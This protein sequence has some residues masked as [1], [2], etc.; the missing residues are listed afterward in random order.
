M[1]HPKQPFF[2]DVAPNTQSCMHCRNVWICV[3]F[4]I[5]R[6]IE[7]IIS[8]IPKEIFNHSNLVSIEER[9][10]TIVV[11]HTLEKQ[12]EMFTWRRRR[13]TARRRHR[14]KG[15]SGVGWVSGLEAL[16]RDIVPHI[17]VLLLSQ[18]IQVVR[19]I[20]LDPLIFTSVF[21]VVFRKDETKSSYAAQECTHSNSYTL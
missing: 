15:S 3:K 4:I 18:E 16:G 17:P 11:S 13:W 14:L 7:F 19:R 5:L 10:M 20:L 1:Y 6:V 21:S 12:N 2:S 8:E 9:L